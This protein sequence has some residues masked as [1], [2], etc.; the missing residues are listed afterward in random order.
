MTDDRTT[1]RYA[2]WGGHVLFAILLAVGVAKSWVQT[3]SVPTL[4]GAAALA[5]W[6]VVGAVSSAR[7]H[8]DRAGWWVVVLLVG[9]I[10]L[11]ALS[12]DFVWLAFVLAI[13]CWRFLPR[14]PAAACAVVITVVSVVGVWADSGFTVGGVI[15]PTIG[16]AT[17]VAVTEAF[18]RITGMVAE[19]DRLVD[20][21]VST[22][23]E[24]AA[25]QREAGVLAERDR[26]GG[27]IHDGVGQYLTSIIMLLRADQPAAALDAA[28]A[29][30]TE[31]RRFLDGIDAPAP[32]GGLSQSLAQQTAA[33]TADGLPTVFAEHGDR[34]DLSAEVQL[35]LWRTAQEALLNV[36]RH[37][38]ASSATVTLTRLPGEVH[39]DVIDDGVGIDA[40]RI[41]AGFGLRAM[42]ARLHQC[43][44]ELVL[45]S[46]PGGGTTVH[47]RIPLEDAR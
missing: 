36:Q 11:V 39:L 32:A 45:D 33:L 25:Q 7:G 44:G 4:V 19:R 37:A 34:V 38:S 8:R 18:H 29:A 30:L 16:I 28:Q 31:S 3:P 27:E 47:A 14:I 46:T 13:L 24:L 6:Y 20:E 22:R 42:R 41:G 10:G 5:A 17:A 12:D 35:A 1:D 23:D 21:L 15:G 9:W 40:A 2:E 43:R 26:L